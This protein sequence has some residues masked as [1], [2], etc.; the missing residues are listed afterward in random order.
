MS[1]LEEIKSRYSTIVFLWK[2]LLVFLAY[3]TS[4]LLLTSTELF[5][6]C[7]ELLGSVPAGKLLALLLPSIKSPVFSF[8]FTSYEVL[9]IGAPVL[10]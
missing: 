1:E 2:Y 4:D 7:I 8:D 5:I 10:F 9:A 6:V 3:S